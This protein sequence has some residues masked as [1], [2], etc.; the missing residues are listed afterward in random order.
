M[1]GGLS[2]HV[3][4]VIG[5]DQRASEVLAAL[6]GQPYRIVHISAHGV[7]D[8]P[9]RDGRRRSGVVLSDG[10]LITAAEIAAMETVPEL[11]V[12]SCCHLGQIDAPVHDATVRDANKLAASVAGELIEIGVRCV[13]AAGWAVDDPQAQLFGETFYRCLL[14]QHLP[15]GDAVHQ[16]RRAV[17]ERKPDDITWGAFQAYGDPGWRAELRVPGARAGTD[18]EPFASPEELLDALAGVRADL[19]RRRPAARETRAQVQAIRHLV[20]ARCPPE[21]RALPLLQSALGATWRDLSRYEDARIAYLKAVQAD[22]RSDRVPIADIEQLA[23]AEGRL[24]ERNNDEALMRSGLE[25]L[26]KLD[27]LVATERSEGQTQGS[28]NS[29]DGA[30][31]ARR[32]PRGKEE[33]ATAQ[34]PNAGRCALRGNAWKRLASLHAR[35][36]L[37]TGLDAEV[38]RTAGVAMRG[39][40]VEAVNAYAQ[41]QGAPGQPRF[42]P[43]L[44]LDRLALDALTPWASDADRDAALSLCQQCAKAAAEAFRRDGGF[45]NAI[46]QPEAA[47]V[48]ARLDGSLGQAGDA[49]DA[50]FEK[51]AGAYREALPN[52]TFKPKELDAIVSQI[53]LLS[54]F[55]DALSVVE[56]AKASR[57]AAQHRRMADRL[58]ALAELLQPGSCRRDDRPSGAT[59]QARAPVRRKSANPAGPANP[60]GRATRH[61]GPRPR[62]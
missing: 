47:L 10:L 32:R 56:R 17:W 9:H 14:Q 18:N 52:I 25:R 15:F 21:W 42:E 55:H 53:G 8:L 19:S 35:Q 28:S 29:V 22:D 38:R 2:W 24:G 13:V 41:A 61:V 30:G 27:L 46:L 37:A 5:A 51:L 45:A 34:A 23:D 12:L 6:Y 54:R 60:S 20:D 1:L 3:Q 57:P 4:Q 44:A 62:K 16:A 39:D 50:L 43:V 59:P 48:Q 40:L 11:V 26:K 49:G 33:V 31:A 58:I 36:A 7:F